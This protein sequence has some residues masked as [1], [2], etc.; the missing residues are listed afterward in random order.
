MQGYDVGSAVTEKGSV[1]ISA[2]NGSVQQKLG[3]IYGASVN[4]ADKKGFEGI[5]ITNGN[6]LDLT[7]EVTGSGNIGIRT[8]DRTGASVGDN[9][10][11]INVLKLT[12]ADA[13]LI[14][15][16][17]DG[18]IVQAYN[19]IT[20][21]DRIDLESRKGSIYGKDSDGAQS[22]FVL[23]GGQN[24]LGSDTLSAS[25]NVSAKGDIWLKQDSGNLRVGKIYA[26]D[27]DIHIAV[28]DGGLVDALP[29]VMR[30]AI[31]E[32]E[33][34]EQWKGMG[35]I[36]GGDSAL[37]AEKDVVTKKALGA[38]TEYRNFSELLP[39]GKNQTVLRSLLSSVRIYSRRN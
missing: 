22:Y 15:L 37:I 9:I 21:A 14:T 34:L 12:G 36:E 24:A 19:Q 23:R 33:L 6:K 2:A 8:N 11:T 25:V 29:Y 35:I 38:E 28:P 26:D 39:L 1:E 4:L 30:T 31:E 3:S 5:N 10:S 16:T 18:N 20:S 27:G 17:A 32:D 13:D 7:V